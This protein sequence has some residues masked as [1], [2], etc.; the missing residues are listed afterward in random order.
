MRAGIAATIVLAAGLGAGCSIVPALPQPAQEP[1]LAEAAARLAQRT[2]C[3]RDWSELD[4]DTRLPAEPRR[5]RFDDPMPVVEIGGQ[6]SYA[7]ALR[8]P[9]SEKPYAVLFKAELSGRWLRSSYLFAPTAVLLDA[10]LRPLRTV[11]VPLCESIGLT[12]ATTGAFGRLDVDDPAARYLV[13]AS[14]ASQLAATTYWEQSPAGLGND[15][16]I[17]GGAALG[18]SAPMSASGSFQIPH[19]PAGVLYV[20]RLT[21]KY[22]RV[23]SDAICGKPDTGQGLLKDLRGALG[24]P[25]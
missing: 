25:F 12:E 1:T 16:L 5:F 6:R 11:D 15:I 24:K 4:F 23:L 18:K 13:V 14:L 19:G 3:C 21:P 9:A 7:L 8:L 22:E 2:P 17:G 10:D 20:G